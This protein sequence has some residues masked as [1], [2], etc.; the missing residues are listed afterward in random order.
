MRFIEG[1]AGAVGFRA[2]R[3]LRRP[4]VR[5]AH[6]VLAASSWRM[7]WLGGNAPDVPRRGAPGTDWCA[8]ASSPDRRVVARASTPVPESAGYPL[9]PARGRLASTGV[10]PLRSHDR[11]IGTDAR[12]LQPCGR[13]QRRDPDEQYSAFNLRYDRARARDATGWSRL[14]GSCDFYADVGI[15][16]I[17]GGTSLAIC[18][19]G[20]TPLSARRCGMRGTSIRQTVRRGCSSGWPGRWSTTTPVRRRPSGRDWTRR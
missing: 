14:S 11:C 20:C 8:A 19:S 1:A 10:L 4:C 6:S 3:R 15:R 7:G 16:I 9:C 13:P 18:P 17:S 12:N 5:D 2:D